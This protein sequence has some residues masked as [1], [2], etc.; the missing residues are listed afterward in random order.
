[1]AVGS[2][3]GVSGDVFAHAGGGSNHAW[4]CDWASAVRA[5]QGGIRE[6]CM[7]IW[8]ALRSQSG[9]EGIAVGWEYPPPGPLEFASLRTGGRSNVGSP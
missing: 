9:Q 2:G 6:G 4:W 8:K 3:H 5:P 1:M 7:R